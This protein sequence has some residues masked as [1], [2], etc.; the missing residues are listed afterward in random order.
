MPIGGR[1]VSALSYSLVVAGHCKEH[2]GPNDTGS[3]S[4]FAAVGALFHKTLKYEL[5]EIMMLKL[6]TNKTMIQEQQFDQIWPEIL[7]AHEALENGTGKGAEFTGW[8]NVPHPIVKTELKAIHEAAEVIKKQSKVLLVIGIGGSYLGALAALDALQSNYSQFRTV[9]DGGIEVLF[10]GHTLSGAYHQKLYAYLQD[11]DFSINVI[12]KSGTTTEPAIAFRLFKGLLEKKYDQAEVRKRIFAT[13]DGSR[14]ALKQLSLHEGYTTFTIPDDIGGRFSV[15][16]A[17][18]LLPL[19]AAG[20]DID[21][22][23][24]GAMDAQALYAQPVKENPCYRYAAYRNILHRSGKAI[25]VLVNYEPSLNPTSEWWKQLYGESE[26][27]DGKGIFPASMSFSTDLHSLGQ[28]VQ[29][30][31]RHLFETVLTVEADKDPLILKAQESD[32]DQL[33][34]L[35]GM[36]LEQVNGQANKGTQL[37]HL[38]GDVPIMELI[39]K[40]MT[41]YAY[42][43]LLYFFMRACGISGYVLGVNP[44]DQPGVEAYKKNMFALLGKAGYED[45]KKELTARL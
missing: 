41:P 7:S 9:K 17:V 45:L 32:L 44:F 37:A 2:S 43:T 12:S 30:G 27:K 19:A 1:G 34:Y 29:D 22:M 25:E 39:L 13:T 23:L 42:G 21:A 31:V 40:E 28:Y 26:G 14:G 35:E 24:Q 16:T 8:L 3:H 4:G 11:K 20:I 33:N 5:K 38:D 15:L 18:G 36:T 10:A 6:K